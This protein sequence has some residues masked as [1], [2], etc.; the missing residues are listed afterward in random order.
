MVIVGRAGLAMRDIVEAMDVEWRL[1]KVRELQ[2]TVTDVMES[3]LDI[4]GTPPVV[5]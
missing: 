5:A 4:N 1:Q 2:L 3:V